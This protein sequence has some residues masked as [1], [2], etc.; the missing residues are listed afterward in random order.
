MRAPQHGTQG[1]RAFTAAAHSGTGDASD[2][3]EAGLQSCETF[4]ICGK[5]GWMNR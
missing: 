5:T 2:A 4:R 1:F 3:I